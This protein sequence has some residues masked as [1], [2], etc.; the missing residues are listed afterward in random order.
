VD[1]HGRPIRTRG[2]QGTS[3]RR[4]QGLRAHLCAARPTLPRELN[5]TERAGLLQ[6]GG[7]NAPSRRP[8]PGSPGRGGGRGALRG[9]HPRRVR[10]LPPLELPS[11]C[12][13]TVTEA[14]ILEPS[15]G[16]HTAATD[17]VCEVMNG[18]ATREHIACATSSGLPSL[19]TGTLAAS[20]FPASSS[21]CPL[22]GSVP[23]PSMRAGATP[24]TVTPCGASE[25]ERERVSPSRAALEAA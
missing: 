3:D 19:P 23:P 11:T 18:L 9:H 6:D 4:G 22:P 12:L 2:C 10:L 24:L 8:R 1:G 7:P 14:L 21:S 17:T 16:V 5:P 15:A 13:I 25:A 20:L